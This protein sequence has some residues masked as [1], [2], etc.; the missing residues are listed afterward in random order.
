MD[1]NIIFLLILVIIMFLSIIFL[2]FYI[3]NISTEKIYASECPTINGYYGVNTN[4]QITILN[5]CG[6]NK[7]EKCIF[8]NIETLNDAQIRCNILPEICTSF[9]YS[10]IS[11]IMNIVDKNF[12]PGGEY[13]VYKR[14]YGEKITYIS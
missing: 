10:E 4:K 7:N 11:K 2:I 1:I 3:V 6:K 5:L 8:Y 12:Y 13:N 14:Q 9:T